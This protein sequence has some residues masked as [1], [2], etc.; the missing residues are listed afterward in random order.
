MF[1]ILGGKKFECKNI[2]RH[3]EGMGNCLLKIEGKLGN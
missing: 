3:T 1:I 2:H